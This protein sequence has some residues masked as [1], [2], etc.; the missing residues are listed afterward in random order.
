[1]I[2]K[3][4]IL[5]SLLSASLAILSF[6][7]SSQ[8]NFLIKFSDIQK[9]IKAVQKGVKDG[10]KNVEKVIKTSQKVASVISKVSAATATSTRQ[11]DSGSYESFALC[12]VCQGV[13]DE[14]IFMRRVEHLNDTELIDMSIEFCEIFELQ[15]P[16]VCRG[17]IELNA[18]S[19]LHIID[20]RED[21][22]SDNICRFLLD[23]GDCASQPDDE[24]LNFVVNI[25]DYVENCDSENLISHQIP[26]DGDDLVIVHITDIHVDFK[27]KKGSLA[28]CKDFA[29]CRYDAEDGD[30]VNATLLAGYWGDYRGCDTPWHAVEDSF[31]QIKKKH[32]VSYN[33]FLYIFFY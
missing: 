4:F 11:G 21:L 27:Y 17:I 16:R 18:P 29:C 19:I 31:E 3:F 28:A 25:D 33:F 23:D 24:H 13:I 20:Y 6:P 7:K 10:V 32:P 26:T 14:F 8:N 2:L 30:N 5:L 15:S 1:M 12:G 9:G 22:T